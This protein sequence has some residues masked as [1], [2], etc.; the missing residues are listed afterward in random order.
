[1]QPAAEWPTRGDVTFGDYSAAYRDDVEPVLRHVNFQAQD[2]Q[3]VWLRIG[4]LV[5]KR[6]SKTP[7][8]LWQLVT[9]CFRLLSVTSPAG[10][11]IGSDRFDAVRKKHGGSL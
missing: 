10:L 1:M 3:K 2:G 8:A 11:L 9:G 6:L 4:T 7:Q 5:H